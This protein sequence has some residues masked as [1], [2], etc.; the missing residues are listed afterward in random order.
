MENY[1]S[2]EAIAA[3]TQENKDKLGITTPKAIQPVGVDV[4]GG[5]TGA[6]QVTSGDAENAFVTKALTPSFDASVWGGGGDAV[7]E[8]EGTDKVGFNANYWNQDFRGGNKKNPLLDAA[9]NDFGLQE[10]G[11]FNPYPVDGAG[12]GDGNGDVGGDDDVLD[13]WKKKDFREKNGDGDGD[14][15][16]YWDQDFTELET[17]DYR[18]DN[19][20][21]LTHDKVVPKSEQKIDLETDETDEEVIDGDATAKPKGPNVKAMGQGFIDMGK[22]MAEGGFEYGDI[23]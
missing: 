7:V 3:R 11:S 5:T 16:D 12:D 1:W 9:Q 6:V 21:T 14:V 20:N 23:F 2:P 13:Y 19:L 18:D 10:D 4:G 17:V 8:G 15:L 22:T